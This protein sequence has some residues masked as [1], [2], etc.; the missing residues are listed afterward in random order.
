[1]SS[2]TKTLLELIIIIEKLYSEID[3]S[4]PY[5]DK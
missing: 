1:M 5:I 3:S 2:S 4:I